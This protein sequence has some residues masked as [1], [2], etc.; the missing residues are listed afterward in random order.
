MKNKEK[1]FDEILNKSL[2]GNDGCSFR[3]N[4]ALKNQGCGDFT[5]DECNE[6]IKEWLEQ[7]YKE[8]YGVL[9]Y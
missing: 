2:I 6:K 7:E 5:C 4:Y 1:Y 9:K 3:L 8:C